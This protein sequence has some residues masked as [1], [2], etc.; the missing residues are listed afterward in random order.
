M[1]AERYLQD[2][3]FTDIQLTGSGGVAGLVDEGAG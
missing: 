3:G 2:E 1:I